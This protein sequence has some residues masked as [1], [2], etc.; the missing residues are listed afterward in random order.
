M[1]EENYDKHQSALSM[2]CL[3][4][5]PEELQLLFVYV[6]EINKS[7]GCIIISQ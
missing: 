7:L 1:T 2:T 4:F 3:R 6:K 5:A